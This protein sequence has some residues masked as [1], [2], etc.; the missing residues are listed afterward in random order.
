MNRLFF[1]IFILL[2]LLPVLQVAARDNPFISQE[3]EKNKIKLPAITTKI[4]GKVMVWQ[5]DLNT[6]L[7]KHVKA[8]K[9]E[10][11]FKNLFP[12]ILI[13]FLYGIAHAVGPGHGKV[14]VFSYFISQKANIKKGVFLGFLIGIF[15]AVS[16]VVTVLSL[17]YIIKTAYLTSFENIS[18]H[19]KTISYSLILFLGIF[20]FL[21][22]LFSITDRLFKYKEKKEG[23]GTKSK[24]KKL[25]P[26]ALAVGIVPC[27]GV[28]IIMLFAL[29]FDLLTVGLAM[30][31]LMALGMGIT[32]MIAG[33]ISILGRQGLVK[34]TS[35]R[36]NIQNYIQK[37]LTLFGALLITGFG[38]I[39]LLG[40]L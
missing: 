26:V 18:K 28:V 22:S 40:I 31:V 35:G 24:N 32:I 11:S 17:Y 13:S 37:G 9:D 4:I 21:N 1:T 6:K 33:L 16:G 29:S 25:L 10:K 23:T 7:T 39:L 19:I 12:L 3:P 20:L 36:Q 14:V 5:Q 34:S 15:H 27:P 8:L 30:S 38:S 2:L